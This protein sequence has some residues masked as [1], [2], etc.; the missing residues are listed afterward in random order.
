L[1]CLN[2]SSTL[3]V[4]M[5]KVFIY[6]SE[7]N[8]V[9]RL[10]SDELRRRRVTV[11]CGLR[12]PKV[13]PKVLYCFAAHRPGWLKDFKV[14]MVNPAIYSK[15]EQYA[16]LTSA[17]V[18][19]PETTSVANMSAL[20][21]CGIDFPL[22]SKP[23]N[24]SH[25]N[26]VVLLTRGNPVPPTFPVLL[27]KY[28]DAGGECFRAL[29]VGDGIVAVSKRTALDGFRAAYGHGLLGHVV[30]KQR[31]T[32]EASDLAVGA[33]AA[34]FRYPVVGVDILV[35]RSG[36]PWICEVN[37]R[38]LELDAPG[39]EGSI[40]KVAVYLESLVSRAR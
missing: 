12:R 24:G 17:G 27:Q 11:E 9:V 2:S 13:I 10:V 16:K 25:S 30:T 7:L 4:E 22:V 8:S 39:M 37:H 19:M 38:I 21:R 5:A 23:L 15:V 36:I 1:I 3:M 31:L 40:P 26:R 34:L 33:A 20:L 18:L 6:G 14:I 28:I 35:D 32:K 29:V